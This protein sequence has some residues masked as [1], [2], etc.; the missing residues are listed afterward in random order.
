M[1]TK[2]KATA[3]T[4][5]MGCSIQMG[6]AKNEVTPEIANAIRALASAAEVN[7]VALGKCADAL[8]GANHYYDGAIGIKVGE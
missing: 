3:P 2:K 8:R 4:S 1:A 7:A 6:P 5:I